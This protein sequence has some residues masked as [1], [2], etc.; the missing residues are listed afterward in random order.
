MLGWAMSKWHPATGEQTG[1][2]WMEGRKEGRSIKTLQRGK[3]W[4][5]TI[6]ILHRVKG[7]NVYWK[8]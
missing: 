7:G 1:K 6:Y 2:R 4:T 8:L 5:L 3:K